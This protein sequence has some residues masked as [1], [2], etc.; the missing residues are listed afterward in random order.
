[1]RKLFTLFAATVLLV[2]ACNSQEEPSLGFSIGSTSKDWNSHLDK[3]LSKGV[4]KPVKITDT[5]VRSYSFDISSDG[6]QFPTTIEFNGGRYHTTKLINMEL[7]VNIDS[8]GGLA[9]NGDTILVNSKSKFSS[10]LRTLERQYGKSTTNKEE[11][12]HYWKKDGF[13]ISLNDGGVWL[14][15]SLAAPARFSP[16][17]SYKSENFVDELFAVTEDVRKQLKPEQMIDLSLLPPIIRT[18][19]NGDFEFNIPYKRL[20]RVDNEEHRGIK[21]MKLDVSYRN[22][23]SDVLWRMDDLEVYWGYSLQPKG[24]YQSPGSLEGKLILLTGIVSRMNKEYRNVRN[25]FDYRGE[26]K[27]EFKIKSVVFEDGQV[28]ND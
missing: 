24:D 10:L 22:A 23:F 18:R 4:L 1:M 16:V 28:L 6:Y 7:V 21:G 11:M 13:T 26:I 25:L 15:D 14:V 2:S 9:P 17:L 19:A 12:V 27:P 20:R 5:N 3:L 8:I